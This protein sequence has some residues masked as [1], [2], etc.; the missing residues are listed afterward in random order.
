MKADEWRE[1]KERKGK[2]NPGSGMGCED[3]LILLGSLQFRLNQGLTPGR[4]KWPA[5]KVQNLVG[6]Y[7][8]QAT[9]RAWGWDGGDVALSSRSCRKEKLF[10]RSE[11]LRR[12]HKWRGE[13]RTQRRPLSPGCQSKCSWM[14]SRT[15]FLWSFSAHCPRS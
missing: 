7:Q 15:S 4:A 1:K 6:C 9:L 8:S 10:K 13:I 14:P 12:V 5:F 3:H 2:Q 11:G